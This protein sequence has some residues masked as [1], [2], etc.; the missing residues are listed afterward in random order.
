M[1]TGGREG[2]RGGYTAVALVFVCVLD[3]CL[4]VA[5][6][7]VCL[8]RVFSAV[9]VDVGTFRNKGYPPLSDGPIFGKGIFISLES[10]W[11]TGDVIQGGVISSS[12]TLQVMALGLDPQLSPTMAAL[13]LAAAT[14][15]ETAF[16]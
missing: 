16:L 11:L 14:Y 13:A 10:P 9:G 15:C 8:V 4:C 7:V 12:K 2:G 3:V 6:R 5:M 1:F